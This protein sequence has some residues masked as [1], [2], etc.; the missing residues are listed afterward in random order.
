M[1][2]MDI[3]FLIFYQPAYNLLVFSS[4]YLG[5]GI[6]LLV[7]IILIGVIVRLIMFP[8]VRRQVM[9][10]NKNSELQEKMKYIKDKYANDKEKYSEEMLKLNSEYMPFM[11]SGCLPLILQIILFINI[12]K[13]FRDL[14]DPSKGISAFAN[15]LYDPTILNTDFKIN[16]NLTIVD[17][18]LTP[19]FVL[20]QQD[21]IYFVPYLIILFLTALIQFFSLKL[22]FS[23]AKKRK[24]KLVDANKNKRDYTDKSLDMS[25]SINKTTEQMMYLFPVLLFFGA[26]NFPLGL[27][28]Y[29]LVQ[30]VLGLIQQYYF[31]RLLNKFSD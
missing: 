24:S 5:G 6:G 30:S 20:N 7:G 3:F 11:L 19:S 10:S 15:F 9:M 31:Y 21:F 1:E 23:Q 22:T 26:M 17:I 12:D 2:N 25:E 16:S 27:T 29:W 28:V 18:S 14:F 8:M 4:Y 13:V